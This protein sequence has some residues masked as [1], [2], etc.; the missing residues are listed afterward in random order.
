MHKGKILLKNKE[1]LH[2]ED[3]EI[4]QR[5]QKDKNTSSEARKKMENALKTWVKIMRRYL[6]L[7][8]RLADTLAFTG[9]EPYALQ[10]IY[11]SEIMSPLRSLLDEV[12]PLFKKSQKDVMFFRPAQGIIAYIHK[13]QKSLAF[14]PGSLWLRNQRITTPLDLKYKW[15]ILKSHKMPDFLDVWYVF[16]RSEG[17]FQPYRASKQQVKTFLEP[18]LLID[19]MFLFLRTA[20]SERW[21]LLVQQVQHPSST[22]KKNSIMLEVLHPRLSNHGLKLYMDVKGIIYPFYEL[23]PVGNEL[24]S[25][26]NEGHLKTHPRSFHGQKIRKLLHELKSLWPRTRVP[27]Q[28]ELLLLGLALTVEAEQQPKAFETLL[29]HA[30]AAKNLLLTTLDGA[31]GILPYAD[32]FVA[33]YQ[34]LTGKNL[35]SQTPISGL[36]YILA[37][38]TILDKSLKFIDK[39][40]GNWSRFLAYAR[41]NLNPTFLKAAAMAQKTLP[42]LSLGASALGIYQT[43]KS[44]LDRI[45]EWK[46]HLRLPQNPTLG[47]QLMKKLSHIYNG[48]GEQL[49]FSEISSPALTNRLAKSSPTTLQAKVRT[50][51]EEGSI[52]SIQQSQKR[53]LVHHKGETL[54]LSWSSNGLLLDPITTR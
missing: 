13:H 43:W 53:L 28:K 38:A 18:A 15:E 6:Q 3:T 39:K 5:Q 32:S 31:V 4:K 10:R 25:L 54:S 46:Q 11:D 45:N 42:Y 7:E 33:A 35:L 52:V 2:K 40:N 17:R 49:R 23:L 1:L 44:T 14:S 26:L 48:T 24:D 47:L 21:P 30:D 36:D 27:R 8:L 51:L 9:K 20:T 12:K 37:S 34:L 19:F 41:R 22:T 29:F 16:A 50:I